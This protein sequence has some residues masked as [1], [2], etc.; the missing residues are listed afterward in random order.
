MI[1]PF[2]IVPRSVILPALLSPPS[3]T[4]PV[5]PALG[6]VCRSRGADSWARGATGGAR[7]SHEVVVAAHG[8]ERQP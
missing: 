6:G 4:P 8:P 3:A 7:D 2:R 5:T 1:D